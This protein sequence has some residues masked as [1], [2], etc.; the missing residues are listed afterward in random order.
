MNLEK[1]TDTTKVRVWV[2]RINDMIDIVS[3]KNYVWETTSVKGKKDYQF[4]NPFPSNAKYSVIYASI[5]LYDSD[6][7][8]EGNVLSFNEAPMEDNYPIKIRYIGSKE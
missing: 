1:I 3:L 6:Y 8:I 5:E 7:I 2:E 4:D